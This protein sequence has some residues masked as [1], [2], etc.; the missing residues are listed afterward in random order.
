MN[1]SI[2]KQTCLDMIQQRGYQP[3]D[4]QKESQREI[5]DMQVMIFSK[6][7]DENKICC[8]L[9]P[10]DKLNTTNVQCV[11][12]ICSVTCSEG[13]IVIYSDTITHTAKKNI[14]ELSHTGLRIE[15]FHQSELSFN[16]TKHDLV[17]KHEK[18]SSDESNEF[19]S[20]YGENQPVL[21]NT[22]P[23]SRFY[24]FSVGDV[25]KITRKNG[26]V[27]YRIVREER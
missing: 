27:S 6:E 1:N 8:I 3:C 20:K 18:L 22:D 15:P 12:E 24:G 21:Y 7:K 17:P 11:Q 4:D 2:I 9:T 23:V 26:Y 16:I 10:F 13:A 5:N 19:K 25:I 14:Y